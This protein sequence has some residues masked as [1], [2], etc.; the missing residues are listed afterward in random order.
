MQKLLKQPRVYAVMF[1][2]ELP[3]VLKDSLFFMTI[4][5]LTME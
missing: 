5:F 2:D 3:Q 4:A 1:K